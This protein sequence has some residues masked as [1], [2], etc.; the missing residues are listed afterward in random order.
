MKAQHRT[1]RWLTPAGAGVTVLCFF[2]P[3]MK[4]SCSGTR[5]LSGY[6]LANH[7]GLLW[8]ILIAAA[9]TLV[10]ST[11]LIIRGRLSRGRF[12]ATGGPL[13]AIAAIV[14]EGVRN[15]DKIRSGVKV[16]G[17]VGVDVALQ[18][19]FFG[20]MIGLLAALAG[21]IVIPKRPIPPPISAKQPLHQNQSV[22]PQAE[23]TIAG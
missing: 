23:A 9:V 12:L 18:I 11:I 1:G 2:L 15:W 21:G 19:G 17:I 3:W 6:D 13:A 22:P 14:F 4:V 8:V 10:V 16:I 20:T 5:S 7:A